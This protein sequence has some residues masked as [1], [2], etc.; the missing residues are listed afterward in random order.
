MAAKALAPL[1]DRVV[2]AIHVCGWQPYI[3]SAR[4]P[5][6]IQAS[7]GS[8]ESFALRIYIWNC[9]PGGGKRAATE[10]RVQLT[11]IPAAAQPLEQV[12]IL[13][14]HASYGVFVAFDPRKHID[15][16]GSSPSAQVSEAALIEANQNIFAAHVNS[17]GETIIAMRPSFLMTYV[18]SARQL[19]NFGKAADLS[20]LNEIGKNRGKSDVDE[21]SEVSLPER[22]EVMRVVKRKIRAADFRDRIMAAYKSTCAMCGT[23]LNLID[24]AH[25]LPVES[26]KST[27][28]TNNGIGLCAL[29][30][31]AF[32][33]ALLSFDTNFK[34][35][36]NDRRIQ[37][38][39]ALKL[40]GGLAAF[41]GGLR[42]VIDLPADKRDHPHS[43]HIVEGRA[44]RRW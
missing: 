29:H 10:Y 9:T 33:G 31:R 44:L 17:K 22:R 24:A 7:D 25:I 16:A 38:L 2:S 20:L 23:Q 12:I 8:G 42:A 18:A 15:Q 34:I 30:H 3:L 28:D 37:E 40:D 5:Y 27:D 11:I 19:H 21:S 36:I 13:G 41:R 14:W 4:N 39:A 6:L 1:L 26:P 32:D 35:E 43:K